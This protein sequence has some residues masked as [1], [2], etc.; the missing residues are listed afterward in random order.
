MAVASNFLYHSGRAGF[1]T[2]SMGWLAGSVPGTIVP[3]LIS[4]YGADIGADVFLSNFGGAWKARGTYLTGKTVA[5]G[6]ADAADTRIAAVGSAG[7]ATAHGILLVNETAASN[8]SLLV[9]HLGVATGL[10]FQ[11]NGGDIDC[12]WSNGAAKIFQL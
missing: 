9:A 4:S 11:P 3:Y 5:S 8:T 6:I 12:E 2:A 10:P 7:A 1:L